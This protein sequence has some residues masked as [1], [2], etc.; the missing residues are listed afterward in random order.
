MQLSAIQSS[1]STAASASNV[2]INSASQSG[3]M[4]PPSRNIISVPVSG[5]NAISHYEGDEAVAQL[6][7][8]LQ[9]LL[10]T[11]TS[12]EMAT[13]LFNAF[14]KPGLVAFTYNVTT[15][16][17]TIEFD[18]EREGKAHKTGPQG[19]GLISGATFTRIQTV[20]G[21]IDRE[22]K[23]ISFE[24]NAVKA[25]KWFVFN[26]SLIKIKDGSDM[27][28]RVAEAFFDTRLLPKQELSVNEVKDTFSALELE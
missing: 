22:Q 13:Y 24:P 23:S 20:K 9:E 21:H 27:K 25:S 5:A 8:I 1:F 2:T 4:E 17:F 18:K 26:A 3:V 7:A 12:G 11:D 6:H 10:T 15:G 14:L 19:F 16:D 28:G